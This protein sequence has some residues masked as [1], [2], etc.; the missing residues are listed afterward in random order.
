MKRTE[1][2]NNYFPLHTAKK[3]KS[4]EVDDE[5]SIENKNS[6]IQSIEDQNGVNVD[7]DVEYEKLFDQ[8]VHEDSCHRILLSNSDCQTSLVLE[9]FHFMKIVYAIVDFMRDP[10]CSLEKD[11]SLPLFNSAE[12]T[13]GDWARGFHS[14]C[15]NFLISEK[16][17]NALLNYLYNT[18]GDVINFPVALT[19]RGQNRARKLLC[20]NSFGDEVDDED[21]DG[22]EDSLSFTQ[23]N[24]ISK[25]KDYDRK[26][27]RWL[28][29]HQ[30]PNDCC[31]FV[32]EQ[33]K[34]FACV[35]C[36]SRRYR[37]CTRSKCGGKGKDDCEHLLND[38]IAYKSMYY[39]LLIPL[40]TDL[41]ETEYFVSALHYKTECIPIGSEDFYSDILDGSV[42]IE[43]LDGMEKNYNAWCKENKAT[44][45]T[46]VNL[47]LMEFYDG[48]Q[49]FHWKTCNFWGLFTSI[50]NLPPTYRGKVGIS[51]FLS[52]LYGGK[53]L[54][55]ER[56]LFTDLYCEELRALYQ[57][58]DY[59][60]ISGKRFFV[61]ARLIFHSLDTKAMEPV[62][63]MQS[64]STSKFGCPYCRNAHGLNNSFKTCYAGNRNFLPW[65]HYLRYF[66]QSGLCCP[67]NFYGP[68]S[69]NWFLEE[70]FLSSTEPI[71]AESLLNG[72]RK[73]AQD[74]VLCKPC[75]RDQLRA[76][77]ILSFL[78]EKTSSYS[79]YHRD[80][81]FDFEDISKTTGG[82]RN[83][84]FYRH[85]DFRPQ[86]VYRRIT[87]EEHLKS[88]CEAREKNLNRTKKE[89]VDGFLGLWPFDRLPYSN[90]PQN[91]SPP[92]D[93]S[94]KG[95]VQHCLEYMLGFY[96]EKQPLRR[97]Y[98]K[99]NSQKSQEVNGGDES[100][101]DYI[102]IYRPSYHSVKAPYSCTTKQFERV[103]A[104]LQCVLIPIGIGDRSDWILDLNHFRM[105]KIS[106]WK[107]LISV[108]WDFLISILTDID[109]WYR[110]FFRMVGDKIRKLL[111]FSV[112]K[113]SIDQ[114]QGE[115]IE[116][117]CLWEGLF[118]ISENYFQLHQIMDLVSSI[119]LFG[120]M[121][122]WAELC[123]E[124]ALGKLKTIKK[125][126]NSGGVSYE[127]NIMNRQVNVELNDMRRFY[128]KSVNTSKQK[129]RNYKSKVY[130]DVEQNRLKFKLMQFDLYDA[131][132]LNSTQQS[133]STHEINFLVDILLMEVRKRYNGDKDT[134]TS[135]SPLYS[136]IL[137][138]RKKKQADSSAYILESALGSDLYSEEEKAIAKALL[139][140]TPIF[141]SKAWIYGLQFRSRGSQCREYLNSV[142]QTVKYGGST[143]N[144]Q[145]VLSWDHK[146][147]LSCWCIFQQSDF[148]TS[149]TQYH[150]GQLNAF[151]EINIGDSSIDG[152]LLASVTSYL[153]QRR[154]PNVDV[155][156]ANESMNP[157]IVFVALQD[158]FPTLIATLPIGPDGKAIRLNQKTT[159]YHDQVT[160]EKI[161]PH[162]SFM[163]K[164]NPDKI[165][166]F[167]KYRSWSMYL[168]SPMPIMDV[169][170]DPIRKYSSV[171]HSNR[172]EQ[173]RNRRNGIILGRPI[174]SYSSENNTA[175]PIIKLTSNPSSH[176]DQFFME[177][178]IDLST[179]TIDLSD[180]DEGA[181]KTSITIECVR[182]LPSYE[183]PSLRNISLIQGDDLNIPTIFNHKD[184]YVIIKKYKIEMTVGKLKCLQPTTWLND[185]VINFYTNMIMEDLLETNGIYSCNTFFMS[186]LFP[187][188]E[189]YDFEA[190]RRWTKNIDI[191][192]LKKIFI[193]INIDNRHW[194]LVYIDVH[195]KSIFYYDSLG[196]AGYTYVYY[197]QKVRESF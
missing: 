13:K 148:N 127:R 19:N 20:Q 105:F 169:P 130:F 126:I 51:T 100:K 180:G 59:V 80:S 116:M 58:F 156:N 166:R 25:I 45:S 44:T 145:K 36:N 161:E 190:V 77:Q 30:C 181:N 196:D 22:D 95:V 110:L 16:A 87:K 93:H 50:V 104:W 186:K 149:T 83:H 114:L 75:D 65:N 3:L 101:D 138:G 134:C 118:P 46:P 159:E 103:H 172:S 121:H 21:V 143:F 34:L 193:P 67:F 76:E 176:H 160:S 71:T 33:E 112:A 41:I 132:K 7:F 184:A 8:N 29:F 66:G 78:R 179:D 73:T 175:N 174:T 197:T 64:M 188:N 189:R 57:G 89:H 140:Y 107:I 136:C 167:P 147:N 5:N 96:K 124:Q 53:H 139:S 62:F 151:F 187:E 86:V 56:F 182:H 92:P 113:E 28:E 42:A 88:A 183:K 141:Q 192:S 178:I 137:K 120:S 70:K 125:R 81:G 163:F 117:I 142:P 69:K 40:L 135:K 31:V 108:Y 146:S 4:R 91:S 24:T 35:I 14:L 39:R 111:A 74:L 17:E 195:N 185:E 85:F 129:E 60:S 102:P 68:D 170:K 171:M 177:N 15:N 157:Q 79:W 158:I 82:I 72:K 10:D 173:I 2:F 131:E 61:Q 90:L 109:E 123:G 162:H 154:A 133:L 106:Q 94:I 47:L 84:I 9:S 55:A 152:L 18:T 119:P 63:N 1:R 155:V 38:G 32:G 37:P 144:D 164:M 153:F 194:T 52:A 48:G 43:H 49:L 12:I 115:V 97:T 23:P 165:S 168:K 98:P 54:L 191:F 99:K 26:G 128:S 11:D 150:Y 6:F 27:S 122:S